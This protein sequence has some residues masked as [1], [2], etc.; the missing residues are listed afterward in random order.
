MSTISRRAAK[1]LTQSNGV[2]IYSYI[3]FL[4][5]SK[6]DYYRGTHVAQLVKHVTSAKVTISQFV[7]STPASGSVPTVQRL[8]PALDSVSPSLS[9]SLKNKSTLKN[10]RYS[11]M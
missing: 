7:G 8:E 5:L 10:G 11:K 3:G 4:F 2:L 9:L 6:D 1:W